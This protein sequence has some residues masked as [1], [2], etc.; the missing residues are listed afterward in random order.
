M[1]RDSLSFG[2]IMSGALTRDR[3]ARAARYGAYAAGILVALLVLAALVVPAFL[4]TPAVERQLQAKL[5]QAVHGEVAW[6]RLSI[7]LLPS[8]R[9]SLSKVRAEIPGVASVSADQ[10]DA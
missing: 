6:E 8:P 7:R 1:R 5:S 2:H 4:D 3:L 10:A 9:G